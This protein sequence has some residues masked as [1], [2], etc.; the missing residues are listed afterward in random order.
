MKDRRALKNPIVNLLGKS[1]HT[2]IHHRKMDSMSPQQRGLFLKYAF[3]IQK[4]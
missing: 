1:G 4:D 3:P 2:R